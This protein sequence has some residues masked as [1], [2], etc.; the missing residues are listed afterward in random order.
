MVMIIMALDHVRDYFHFDSF[1]YDPV[2]VQQTT[3]NLFLTRWITHLCAPTFIFLAGSSAY[4]IG[5]RKT[6]KDTAFFLLSRG[7]WLIVLQLTIIR[8]A[9][10]FDPFFHYNSNTIISVIGFCMIALSVLIY[11]PLRTILIIGLVLV[12]GHNLLDG[13]TFEDGT[14]ADV[15]WSFLHVQKTFDLGNDYSFAFLY[16]VMPWIGVIALGYCFGRLYQPDYTSQKRRNILLYLGGASL[17]IFIVLRLSNVYGDPN[18]WSEYAETR[19]T[20]LSF[21]NLQKYPPSFLYLSATLGISLLLLA[22]MEEKNLSHW[23]HITL[24]GN[25][26]LFYYVLHIFLIHM[27]ALFVAVVTGYPWDAMVFTGSVAKGTPLLNGSYGFNLWSVYIVWIGV[28]VL[29]YPF[30]VY[31]R[32]FKMRNKKKWWISYI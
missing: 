3:V 9:W 15:L 27:L 32:S 10:N 31:W 6:V 11:F 29:L 24:F 7:I 5:K 23:K 18:P 14:A 20:L 1:L 21:F 30:C 13:I 12:A 19:T 28:V 26:A 22:A 2:D 17:I 25:V 8:F 16:P 4:F